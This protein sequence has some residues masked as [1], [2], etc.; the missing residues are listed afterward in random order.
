[1]Q[2]NCSKG[3]RFRCCLAVVDFIKQKA[4][5]YISKVSEL[6]QI[7]PEGREAVCSS[8]ISILS[9]L[10]SLHTTINGCNK[11]QKRR[12]RDRKLWCCCKYERRLRGKSDLPERGN[13]SVVFWVF[14]VECTAS[15]Q[16]KECVYGDRQVETL[17]Y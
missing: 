4:N 9:G 13:N 7:S 6:L 14:C 12:K 15:L 10:V 17:R 8:L 2:L 1:M 16:A 11:L 5:F 3:L